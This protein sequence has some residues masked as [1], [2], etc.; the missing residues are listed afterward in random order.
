MVDVAPST[1]RPALILRGVLLCGVRSVVAGMTRAAWPLQ[2]APMRLALALLLFIP[3]C[4]MLASQFLPLGLVLMW[5]GWW[6]YERSGLRGG[7]GLGA[8][9]MVL[10]ALG[11]LAIVGQYIAQRL[12]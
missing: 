6:M 5:C 4:L 8:V 11:A 12:A 10:G 7:D 3:G 1:A 9:V 2:S